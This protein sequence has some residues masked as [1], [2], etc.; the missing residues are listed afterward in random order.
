MTEQLKH[1]GPL[2]GIRVLELGQL[3]AGPFTG[4]LLGYYGAEVIKVEAPGEGDPIRTWRL[5]DEGTSLWWR[6]VARNKKCVT[7]NLRPE[8]GRE[9]VRQL[10]K[11]SDVLIENF[12]PGAMERWGLGPDE[13]MLDN[14]GLIYARI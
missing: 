14:P 7:A 11:E 12:R 6:S 4:C 1:P 8:E 2:E 10:A 5:L 3:I 13:L 9:I